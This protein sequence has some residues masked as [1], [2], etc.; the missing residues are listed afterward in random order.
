LLVSIGT[1]VRQLFA[2]DLSRIILI[3]QQSAH[4]RRTRRM[5][6]SSIRLDRSSQRRELNATACFFN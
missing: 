4:S 2:A 5:L 3:G 1:R 6:R